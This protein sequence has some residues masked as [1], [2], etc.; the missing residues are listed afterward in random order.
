MKTIKLIL[1]TLLLVISTNSYSQKELSDYKDID[2]VYITYYWGNINV[3][4]TAINKKKVF[5]IDAKHTDTSKKTVS[6][7]DLS[8]FVNFEVIQKKL[9]IQTRKPRGFESIDLNLKIPENLFLEIELLKGG[10]IYAENLKNGVEINTLNGSVKLER[11][12]KYAL[13][14]AANGEI[15]TSFDTID[16]NQPISLVTINGGVTVA[17][18]DSAKRDLRLISRKNGYV[19]SDFNIDSDKK[20]INLNSKQ[21]S[22]QPIINTARINGGGSLLF[23]STENGPIAIK[24]L[25]S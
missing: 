24:K 18:P 15:V 12:G 5:N 7:D 13:V 3:I 17:L 4:G 14:N 25:K 21:Y 8:N 16:N 22:R 10:E 20:I 11:I 23:L 1:L 9:Y 19:E 6:I 2:G